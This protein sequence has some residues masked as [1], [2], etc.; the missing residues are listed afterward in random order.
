[1]TGTPRRALLLAATA[2]AALAGW[3][4]WQRPSGAPVPAP[5]T[6][7]PRTPAPEA[8]APPAPALVAAAPPR[9]A[10]QSL[11][12]TP[13]GGEPATVCMDAT[14]VQQTGSVR[15]YEIGAADADGWRLAV[16]TV[17][18]RATAVT[19]RA[20]DG[21]RYACEAG[22]CAAAVQVDERASGQARALVLSGLRLAAVGATPA[23]LR[24]DARLAIPP[25][26]QLPG[27]ACSEAG[28]TMQAAD[29]SS[30]RFCGQGGSGVEL[31]DD[32][33]RRYRFEDHEGRTLRIDVDAAER[34]TGVD[35]AGHGCRGAA[36]TG[37]GTHSA[38]PANALAQRRFSFGRTALY[39][40]TDH[41]RPVLVLDGT[42]VMPGQP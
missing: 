3:A 17:Q 18:R 40:G 38:E 30:Q 9:C 11:V 20:R 21:R 13:A 28:V 37:V 22:A 34:V 32:G 42:L 24:L 26:D 15:R 33:Q 7:V 14:R 19:L 23:E 25:E 5:E 2:A 36:C 41:A 12:L 16:D 6:A 39:A 10:L 35:W 1:M 4:A 29:G 8:I 31:A 27:L